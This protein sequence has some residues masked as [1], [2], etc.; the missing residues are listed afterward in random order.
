M[1]QWAPRR[2][3]A[4]EGKTPFTAGGPEPLAVGF[5]CLRSGES[6]LVVSDRA[7]GPGQQR[8]SP[9][10]GA[11]GASCSA[12][13]VCA[14]ACARDVRGVYSSLGEHIAAA[15][16]QQR[17]VMGRL[18]RT[19]AA[20]GREHGSATARP[21]GRAA[22]QEQGCA[23]GRRL[24]D[25]P[26]CEQSAPICA[27]AHAPQRVAAP[28][29]HPPPWASSPGRLRALRTSAGCPC[30]DTGTRHNLPAPSTVLSLVRI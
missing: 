1:G 17:S 9:R 15:A 23:I 29:A 16:R 19:K 14:K 18:S 5:D 2:P 10:W 25:P 24:R 21:P 4:S 7:V 3:M 8:P 6:S 30:G 20:V 27:R 28:R 26:P 11:T 22:R 13:S 12:R